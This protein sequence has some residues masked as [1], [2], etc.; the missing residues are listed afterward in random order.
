MENDDHL[1]LKRRKRSISLIDTGHMKEASFNKDDIMNTVK[2]VKKLDKSRPV[3]HKSYSRRN[4]SIKDHDEVIDS[5]F[6]YINSNK[7]VG[8]IQSPKEETIDFHTPKLMDTPVPGVRNRIQRRSTKPPEKSSKNSITPKTP[9]VSPPKLLRTPVKWC[10]NPLIDSPTESQRKDVSL[11]ESRIQVKSRLSDFTAGTRFSLS[12]RDVPTRLKVASPSE[13]KKKSK[14]TSL[15]MKQGLRKFSKSPKIVLKYTKTKLILKKASPVKLMKPR[16]SKCFTVSSSEAAVQSKEREKFASRKRSVTRNDASVASSTIAATASTATDVALP[17]LKEPVVVLQRL[18]HII[19][20]VSSPSPLSASLVETRI[21]SRLNASNKNASQKMFNSM[22][23]HSSRLSKSNE[24]RHLRAKHNDRSTPATP[25]KLQGIGE[26]AVS[27][28]KKSL[29]TITITNPLMSSTPRDKRQQSE[30]NEEREMVET[31]R[32]YD[33]A[34]ESSKREAPYS[35]STH[36]ETTLNVENGESAEEEVK[37][38]DGTYELAEPKTPNLRKKLQQQQSSKKTDSNEKKELAKE[39]LKVRFTSLSPDTITNCPYGSRLR[40]SRIKK[41]AM[42][43]SSNIMNRATPKKDMLKSPATGFRTRP[44]FVSRG[45]T[46]P[47]VVLRRPTAS[48]S[49]KRSKIRSVTNPSVSSPLRPFV[50]SV[51]QPGTPYYDIPTRVHNVGKIN[52]S[53]I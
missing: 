17:T 43:N 38:K 2:R 44:N 22:A 20:F 33:T 53:V 5:S 26:M 18:S 13:A 39:S 21:S 15:S 29:P 10:L 24:T 49:Q 42:N 6:D 35:P 11:K 9:S 27:P 52:A 1:N 8:K 41:E 14:N 3:E 48:S 46:S 19:P 40:V 30:N 12:K 16:G 47:T 50:P 45:A 4:S 23:G 36:Q 25:E 32:T 51:K 34:L 37:D 28:L 7:T 31:S